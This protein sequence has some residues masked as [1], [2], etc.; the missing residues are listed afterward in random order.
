MKKLRLSSQIAISLLTIAVLVGLVI[1]E[2]ERRFETQRLN[3]ALKEQADLTVSLIGGLLIEAILV[4][5]TP[6]IDTAIEEAVRR[7]PKL[8]AITV[9]DAQGK[10][11]SYSSITDN[12]ATKDTHKYSKDIFFEGVK[13]GSMDVI[14]S[15]VLGQQLINK[16]V[17]I[18]RIK[19]FTTL[20]II[21]ALFMALLSRLAMRP[22]RS[23]H[24]RMTHT[25]AQDGVA[26]DQLS[27]FASIEF[28]ALNKSVTTLETA[29]S[30]RDHREEALKQASDK[31]AKASKAKSEFLANMSHE[32][33]TPMNGVIGMAELILETKLDQDQKTYAETISKSGAALLTIINDILDFSKIEAGKLELDPEAFDLH[34]A[35]EDVVTLVAAKAS[36]KDVEVTLRYD[37]ELPCCYY[38][39]VGR[40]RQI[41]TNIIGNA[42]KFTLSG[43][44]LINVSGVKKANAIQLKFEVED[45]GI[46]IPKEKINNIFNEFEQVEGSANRSFEG[47]GLGLAISTRL[48][49]IMGGDIS[50]SSDVGKGSIFTICFELPVSNELPEERKRIHIDFSG[51]MALI[52]DDLTVNLNILSERLR[53]W[54]V[55]CQTASSGKRALQI[56]KDWQNKDK[57]FDFAIL[58]FQM[59]EMHGGMLAEQIRNNQYYDTLPLIMLSSVDQ[60]IDLATKKRLRIDQT[61][62]K[63]ARANIL[64]SAVASALKIN[65]QTQTNKQDP[66]P[67]INKTVVENPLHIL[68]AEDNKTNQ[69][70]LKTMLKVTNAELTIAQ[71]GREAVEIYSAL[72]PDLILMDMSM[73]EMD[74][75]EATQKI[76]C[77][78]TELGKHRA[79]IIAL[80]VYAMKGGRQQ[81]I[82]AGMD[83]YLSKPIRK[84]ILLKMIEAWAAID[85]PRNTISPPELSASA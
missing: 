6:V 15:T 55:T 72:K 35:L 32:I 44:V 73:P 30:E 70:V 77:L 75:L 31:A 47:T 45:T 21:S 33:R 80:T 1:G 59:P 82:D 79:P 34:R 22:L 29:L 58:D 50:V 48:I 43:Y 56:L 4:K 19:T 9:F 65:V 26:S 7:N 52:V 42:A 85:D 71:N 62:L 8:L 53:S 69:L 13:F 63:P 57:Q 5:D 78:E 46:G 74:G 41:V 18:A 12:I 24:E 23:V 66:Q 64:H 40:I 14:W 2:V 67:P 11:L 61:L 39:D 25:I 37:P 28:Q 60:G 16:N 68:V 49:K 10:K 17:D 38:G 76:R 27:K 51:K 3:F 20:T 81:C 36:Q 83:D 54:G 84:D